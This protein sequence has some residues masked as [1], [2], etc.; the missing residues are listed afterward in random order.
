MV[1]HFA[2]NLSESRLKVVHSSKHK[3]S[4]HARLVISFTFAL[5]IIL[6]SRVPP[7]RLPSLLTRLS[8]VLHPARRRI[9]GRKTTRLT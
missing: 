1:P 6:I 4:K 9:A 2:Y 5:V 3:P 7:S 8:G